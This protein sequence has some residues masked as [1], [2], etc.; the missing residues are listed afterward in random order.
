MEIDKL[1]ST[2]DDL[3]GLLKQNEEVSC[4]IGMER[5]KSFY[6]CIIRLHKYEKMRKNNRTSIGRTFTILYGL[7]VG[8]I[9]TLITLKKNDLDTAITIYQLGNRYIKT[10]KGEDIDDE[11]GR[12]IYVT[13]S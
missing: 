12:V 11:T 3:K 6:S 8:L 9:Q 10:I 2:Y 4:V 5:K 13:H 7:Y 1:P